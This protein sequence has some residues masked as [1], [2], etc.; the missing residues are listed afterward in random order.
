MA[1]FCPARAPPAG[2][3]VFTT[4]LGNTVL[5]PVWQGK[6]PPV[7]PEAQTAGVSCRGR[8]APEARPPEKQKPTQP[9]HRQ[10]RIPRAPAGGA[11]FSALLHFA[12]WGGGG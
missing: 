7:A 3:E 8:S 12:G 11:R 1:G 5:G 10:Q 4:S 2:S 6:A 9:W